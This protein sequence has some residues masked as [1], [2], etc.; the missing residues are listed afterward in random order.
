[1]A[2]GVL[3]L[4]LVGQTTLSIPGL[5]L[6]CDE[7]SHVAAG[8]WYWK[9]GDFRM[10]PETP[11]L[12]QSYATIPLLFTRIKMPSGGFEKTGNILSYAAKL[13]RANW[14]DYHDYLIATRLMIAALSVCFACCVWRSARAMHGAS[15]GIAALFLYCFS[16]NILAHSSL[17]TTDIGC[18]FLIFGSAFALWRFASAWESADRVGGLACTGRSAVVGIATG[19]ALLAKMTSLCLFFLIGSVLVALAIRA[20][21]AQRSSARRIGM[22]AAGAV[23]IVL[24]AALTVNVGYLFDGSGRNL[25]EYEFRSTFLRRVKHVLPPGTPVPLP[26]HYVDGFDRL[27]CDTESRYPVFLRGELST[28]GWWHYYFLAYFWK[29]PIPMLILLSVA[30][31]KRLRHPRMPTVADCIIPCAAMLVFGVMSFLTDI[32]IGLR[33]VLPAFAFIFVWVAPALSGLL[34]ARLVGRVAGVVLAAGYAASALTV[35]PHHLSY[36]N[37][38]A[39]GPANGYRLLV[40]SNIDWGQD[41]ISLRRY[42]ADHDIPRVK[43]AYFGPLV[44]PDMYGVSHEHLPDGPTTGTI[45]ISVSLLQGLPQIAIYRRDSVFTRPTRSFEWLK[46]FEPIGRAGYSILIFDITPADLTAK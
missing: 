29:V 46:A 20:L 39:G 13:I 34:R 17:L 30:I 41:L 42:I 24:A 4:A 27:R 5:S 8:L 10:V 1:V 36:F 32:N 45:A 40:D 43:I 26:Y 28:K 21:L 37:W 44:D 33:Y 31:A 9:R 18:S 25:S 3:L 2:V 35:W 11:P 12:I 16:P 23:V 19:L 6:T 7:Q 15:A 14:D 22:L 38:V